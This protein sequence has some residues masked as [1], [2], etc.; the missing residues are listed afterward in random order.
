MAEL[1]DAHGSGPCESNFMEVR[2]LLP[3]PHESHVRAFALGRGFL[4]SPTLLL[5]NYIRAFASPGVT[6]GRFGRTLAS[7]GVAYRPFSEILTFPEQLLLFRK[8]IAKNALL[9]EGFYII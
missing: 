1:A 6:C 3:A 5:A 4:L 9:S 8:I 7:P 2:L